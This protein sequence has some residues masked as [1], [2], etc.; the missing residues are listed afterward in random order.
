MKIGL[1]MSGGAVHGVAHLGALK[2][3]TEL[4]IPLHA[5]SGV[6]S[7]AI[8]GAFFAAGY[9][10]EEIY[11]LAT[12]L[13]YWQLAKPA[14][15]KRGLIRLDKLEKEFSKYLGNKTFEDLNL[16][17]FICATDLRQGTTVYFSSGNL[18]TPLLASNTVPLLSP[19]VEYQNHLLVDGGL[20]NNLPVECLLN[21]TDFRIALHVNPMNTQ[22]ELK[23]FR[24]ILER[25][26]H[27]AINNNVHPRLSLCN[28]IIE[29]PALKYFSLTDLK[30]ARFMFEAGYEHTISLADKLV[31]LKNS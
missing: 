19:P 11:K 13:P 20:L 12:E 25:T 18:I 28:L 30:N 29:P 6:S 3:L 4:Q 5:I 10:P 9:T 23:T 7:G 31:A 15:N 8:A 26:C 1:V 16:P 21:I 24:S 2:A 27:L 17:L 22:A 14:F